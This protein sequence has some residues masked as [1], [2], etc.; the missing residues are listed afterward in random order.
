MQSGR[1]GVGI[2]VHHA[3]AWVMGK[4]WE[5]NPMT[6][7]SFHMWI[8]AGWKLPRMPAKPEKLEIF[9]CA[10]KQS[11]DSRRREIVFFCKRNI[12]RY[13]PGRHPKIALL[14]EWVCQ[15]T[16]SLWRYK[17]WRNSRNLLIRSRNLC[18]KRVSQIHWTCQ[19]LKDDELKLR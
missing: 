4:K 14:S 15:Y 16:A 8:L 17:N 6:I 1:K 13:W 7:F 18:L 12:F 11:H 2:E 5:Y 10:Y 3:R 19:I 9:H